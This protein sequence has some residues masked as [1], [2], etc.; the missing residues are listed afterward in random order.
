M[1]RLTTAAVLA[2]PL[3]FLGCVTTRVGQ[4]GP[5]PNNEYLVTLI[6]SDDRSAVERECRDVPALG[7]VV[8]CEMSRAVSLG[9]SRAVRAVKIVRYAQ[10]L[11]SSM[12]FEIDIHELCHTVAS[13][14]DLTDPCHD[15]NGGRILSAPRP[16]AFR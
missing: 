8:G 3:F 9:D 13:L 1:S 12:T 6:V 2:A 15:G 11:P 5:L 7:P 4:F 14:Q 16:P 10:Q